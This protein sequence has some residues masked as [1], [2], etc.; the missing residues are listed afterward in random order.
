MSVSVRHLLHVGV[1][2]FVAALL[3]VACRPQSVAETQTP[4][5]QLYVSNCATCHGASGQG[6]GDYPK[7]IGVTNILNGDYARTVIAQGRNKMAAFGTK[8]TPEQINEIVD[9]IATF[10]K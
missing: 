2:A 7:L 1:S 6:V 3:I 8:L 9:Y 10:K 4:G 5:G